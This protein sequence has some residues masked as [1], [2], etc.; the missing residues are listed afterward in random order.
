MKINEVIFNEVE[1]EISPGGDPKTVKPQAKRAGSATSVADKVDPRELAAF[2][3][4]YAGDTTYKNFVLQ[5]L[6]SPNVHTMQDAIAYANSKLQARRN[7]D[8]KA[9]GPG[10]AGVKPTGDAWNTD[11]AKSDM[12]NRGRLKPGAPDF[13]KGKNKDPFPGSQA[14]SLLDL[15]P[16]MNAVRDEI[17][18][19]KATIKDKTSRKNS[20]GEKVGGID[21]DGASNFVRNRI[22]KG[23][24]VANKV[25]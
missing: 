23:K 9:R 3:A 1:P 6:Q 10:R 13:N 19:I 15:I 18:T 11:T 14:G 20:S 25:K 5:A 17:N 2:Q 21:I 8:D 12:A 16:G 7:A 22:S 4:Q 24:A